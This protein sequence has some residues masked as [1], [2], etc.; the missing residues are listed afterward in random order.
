MLRSEKERQRYWSSFPMGQKQKG[1]FSK[2]SSYLLQQLIHRYQESEAEG[3]EDLGEPEGEGESE[4][5]S[6]SEMQNLEVCLL[7]CS[8]LP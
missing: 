4:E 3:E 8:S 7:P 6:D 5:S 1:S 2:D